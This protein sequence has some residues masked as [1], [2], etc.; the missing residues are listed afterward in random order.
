MPDI[1][2]NQRNSEKD[3]FDLLDQLKSVVENAKSIPFSE[4]CVI[5]RNDALYWINQIKLSYPQEVQ[6]AKWIVTQNQQV[7]ASARQKAESILRESE[8]R[9]AI[10]VDE[11]QITKTA[12]LKADAILTD[13]KSNADELN[14]RA[15]KYAVD[16]IEKVE[17]TLESLLVKLNENKKELM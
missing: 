9:Q 8:Q 3:L 13:A 4:N 12:Q 11:H 7:V 5:D 17:R 6:Q 14:R 2:Q 1:P 15:H 10:M 16:Q